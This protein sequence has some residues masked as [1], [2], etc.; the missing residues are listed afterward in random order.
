MRKTFIYETKIVNLQL[1]DVDLQKKCRFVCLACYSATLL[2]CFV[3]STPKSSTK[4]QILMIE[5]YYFF[6]LTLAKS[7]NLIIKCIQLLDKPTLIQKP[8]RLTFSRKN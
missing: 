4:Y 5:F 2:S 6:L 7:V 8:T 1:L 3:V